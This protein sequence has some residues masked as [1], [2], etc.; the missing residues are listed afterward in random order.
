MRKKSRVLYL[1]IARCLAIV[2]VALNHSVNR[3]YTNYT[4]QI[5]EFQSIPLASSVWRTDF[6]DDHRSTSASQKV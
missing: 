1:D 2:L 5:G 3:C 4:D 6:S